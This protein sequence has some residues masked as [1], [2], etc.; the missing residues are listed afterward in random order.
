MLIIDNNQEKKEYTL[1]EKEDE[2][3]LSEEDLKKI[4]GAYYREGPK[5]P[6]CSG[7]KT[8]FVNA[9]TLGFPYEYSFYSCFDCSRQFK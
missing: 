4:A 7:A 8:Y 6:Y 1:I 9:A 2:F 5:R 3:Q